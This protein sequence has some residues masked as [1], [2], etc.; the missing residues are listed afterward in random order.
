[1]QK[2]VHE[3]QRVIEVQEHRLRTLDVA[4]NKL[5]QVII[6]IMMIIV[7]I[8]MISLIRIIVII[9][10]LQNHG[11]VIYFTAVCLCVSLCVCPMFS[12]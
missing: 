10:H 9:T 3:K 7:I 8:I 1:M 11:G 5:L 2:V 12:C 6:M 4:N